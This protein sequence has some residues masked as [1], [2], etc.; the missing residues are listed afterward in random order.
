MPPP[1]SPPFCKMSKPACR[2]GHASFPE[3]DQEQTPQY[4]MGT[5]DGCADLPGSEF[6]SAEIKLLAFC[7]LTGSDAQYHFKNALAALL[8]GFIP[9][10]NGA[11][12]DIHIV[13]HAPI[14]GRVRGELDRGGR[15][16]AEHAAAPGG[17]THQIGSARNLAGG[18]NRVVARRVHEHETLRPP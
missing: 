9:V 10:Q 12:V 2:L 18:G 14:H 7:F 4:S 3:G 16:A 5:S 11:A 6:G 8:N 15:F 13:F 1:S 17:E